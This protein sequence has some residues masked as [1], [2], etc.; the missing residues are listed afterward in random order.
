MMLNIPSGQLP[1]HIGRVLLT[2][3]MAAALTLVLLRAVFA[4]DAGTP[5]TEETP[6]EV[7]S[8]DALTG[9][10]K[11]VDLDE[12]A[13]AAVLQYTIA[14]SNNAASPVLDAWVTDT[15]PA[16][17]TY[18]TDSLTFPEASYGLYNAGIITWTG[19][20]AP[21]DW[22]TITFQATLA[23]D[24]IAGDMVTNTAMIAGAG[25]VIT[26]SAATTI[27]DVPVSDSYMVALPVLSKSF[28]YV[29]LNPISRPSAS[30]Q[31]L[32]TWMG[33]GSGI[34]G[35]EIHESH[36]ADFAA[37]TSYSVGD[38]TSA[39]VTQPLSPDNAY[40]YR[41]RA[42]GTF[43]EGTWSNVQQVV[44]GYRDDFDDAGTGWTVRRTSLWVPEDYDRHPRS[45]YIDG[46]Y[47]E[48]MMNDRWDWFVTSP[49]RQAPTPPYVIEYQAQLVKGAGVPP[50]LVSH[51]AILGGDWNGDACPEIGNVYET[52][53]CFNHFYNFNVIYH[54][55]HKLLFERVDYLDFCPECG[56]SALKRL[57]YD[58]SVWFEEESLTGNE[59]VP[60]WHTYRIEVRDTGL[61]F[62]VDGVWHGHTS[63]TS[64][65]NDPY[66]G[67]FASTDEYR[68]SHWYVDYYQITPLD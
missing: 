61:T 36:T 44:G 23:D 67:L 17:L 32:L 19:I 38:T 62:Y 5:A 14:I 58:Y 56:G 2:L 16:E 10:Q 51:G 40:F 63:D 66:F 33:M 28:P 41:V 9:S 1:K 39:Q 11:Q 48:L 42:V 3:M 68:P 52:D 59:P 4:Q 65:I 46:G 60:N 18:I 8:P 29:T 50:N 53:N 6:A 57:S 43:G 24:L 26:R 15:L 25:A 49:L 31:W 21:H 7:L 47:L 13:A 55:P 45:T 35:Y 27:I 34:E 12:A 54:G 30:N 20:I 37:F 64:Y 22:V